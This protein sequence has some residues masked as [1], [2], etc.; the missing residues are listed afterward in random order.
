MYKAFALTELT[1]L[2]K[3]THY[4]KSINKIMV[5]NGDKCYEGNDLESHQCW[6]EGLL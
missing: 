6:D 2:K 5:L 1:F 4:K 3:K